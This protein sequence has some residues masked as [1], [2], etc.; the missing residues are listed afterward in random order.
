MGTESLLE[1]IVRIKKAGRQAGLQ[2]DKNEVLRIEE[3]EGALLESYGF[4]L[5]YR[6]L[7]CSQVSKNYM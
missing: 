5:E 7:K 2:T 6:I 3:H 4:R 1:S